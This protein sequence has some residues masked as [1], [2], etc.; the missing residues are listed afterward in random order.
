MLCLVA[1]V[2]HPLLHV[3]AA[4]YEHCER[5]LPRVRLV[6]VLSKVDLVSAEH[7][8][9]WRQHLAARWPQAEP[10]PRS[11]PDDRP[12]TRVLSHRLAACTLPLGKQGWVT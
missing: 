12:L 9:E 3:P 6:I 2:R 8:E 7:L 10:A 1:D 4:L 5:E 11:P